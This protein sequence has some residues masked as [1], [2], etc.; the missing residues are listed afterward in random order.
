MF[1]DEEFACFHFCWVEGI[2]LGDFGS[3][4]WTEFDDVVIGMM[5]GKLIMGFL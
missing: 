2:D 5:R 1:F 3:E 4:A